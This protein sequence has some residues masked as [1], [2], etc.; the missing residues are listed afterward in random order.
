MKN[1]V[2]DPDEVLE[3]VDMQPTAIPDYE[4]I[5][6][7]LSENLQMVKNAICNIVCARAAF[8]PMR[9]T[10]NRPTVMMWARDTVEL[11]GGILEPRV[12]LLVKAGEPDD[13]ATT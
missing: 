6:A 4:A 5:S 13:E 10:E 2:I 1:E 7:D 11:I 3:Y 9:P 12:G 8:R